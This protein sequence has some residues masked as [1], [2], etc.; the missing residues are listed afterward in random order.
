MRIIILLNITS[1]S[2]QKLYCCNIYTMASR[3]QRKQ[4]RQQRRRGTKRGGADEAVTGATNLNA[5]AE[6]KKEEGF[7]SGIQN[8]L[9]PTEEKQP[10]ATEAPATAEAAAEPAAIPEQISASDQAPLPEEKPE[11]KPSALASLFGNDEK[12]AEEQPSK[13]KKNKGKRRG[14]YYTKSQLKAYCSR[15]RR[16]NRRRSNRRVPAVAKSEPV[17][18]RPPMEPIY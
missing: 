9:T 8:M 10:P 7:L 17:M 3:K 4:K 5:P 11:E 1:I 14:K 16:S 18:Y 13:T 2:L 15:R 12:P 6:E